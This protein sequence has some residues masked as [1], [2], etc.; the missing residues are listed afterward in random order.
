MW[1]NQWWLEMQGGLRTGSLKRKP[2]KI[3]RRRSRFWKRARLDRQNQGWTLHFSPGTKHREGTLPSSFNHLFIH[4]FIIYA[5]IC[6]NTKH[7]LQRYLSEHGH[8]LGFARSKVP[9][10]MLLSFILFNASARRA[11]SPIQQCAGPCRPLHANDSSCWVIYTLW[12]VQQ[13]TNATQIFP[14]SQ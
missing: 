12:N 3:C 5:F 10:P 4:L 6:I 11:F 13:W 1:P 2:N 7:L 14:I 9:P 8:F